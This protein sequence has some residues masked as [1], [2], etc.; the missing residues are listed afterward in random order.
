MITGS[1]LGVTIDGR[2]L[3]LTWVGRG[4]LSVQK[5]RVRAIDL[6]EN[7]EE[8]EEFV[9]WEVRDFL[10]AEGVKPNR[11]VVS[12]P[13]EVAVMR[14]VDLP[15][16]V[17]ANVDEAVS[18]EAEKHIP[19]LGEE[20]FGTHWVG[21]KTEG[22]K[23]RIWLARVKKEEISTVLAGLR[24]A[25]VG[26]D[27]LEISAVSLWR[28]AGE[29]VGKAVRAA[30]VDVRSG[31][32][33]V[34]LFDGGELV[35]SRAEVVSASAVD[36][37]R[38]KELV[39]SAKASVGGE[40]VAEGAGAVVVY[41]R[42][43]LPG[44]EELFGCEKV[45]LMEE[46]QGVAEGAAMGGVE[47]ERLTEKNLLPPEMRARRR[48]FGVVVSLVLLIVAM[49]LFLGGYAIRVEKKKVA[50]AMVEGQVSDARG[51][52]ERAVEIREELEAGLRTLEDFQSLSAKHELQA[53][54]VL[55]ELTGLFP[56]AVRFERFH[57]KGGDMA[58]TGYE[59]LGT[60]IVPDLERSEHFHVTNP[61]SLSPRGSEKRFDN[62]KM[63]LEQ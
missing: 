50:L 23:V 40:W 61:G 19:L 18:Y 2:R 30:V 1:C 13:R 8:I 16:A 39:E 47:G 42:A 54:D 24:S 15:E 60:D 17:L 49:A 26:T 10:S 22:K 52:Y 11:V 55:Y 53:V 62:I 44:A 36:G 32:V 14:L 25:A 3:I 7:S 28:S 38:L 46:G 51:D 57:L 33:E 20:V 59:P 48:E 31:A 4:V 58:L 41:G 21:G 45:V 56:V 5:G 29:R 43:E 12:V 6:P 35:Y 34:D 37:E 9:K 27:V 63:R